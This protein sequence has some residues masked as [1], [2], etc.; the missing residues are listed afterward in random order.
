MRFLAHRWLSGHST[1]LAAALAADFSPSNETHLHDFVGVKVDDR[2]LGSRGALVTN[3]AT[4]RN[5]GGQM[6]LGSQQGGSSPGWIIDTH[7]DLSLAP[8]ISSKR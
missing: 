1:L 5:E 2:A 8:Q 4:R 7:W 3:P 6:L